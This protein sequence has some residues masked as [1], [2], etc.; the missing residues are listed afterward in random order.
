MLEQIYYGNTVSDYLITISIII[1]MFL[2]AYLSHKVV[3]KFLKKLSKKSKNEYDDVIAEFLKGISWKFY[4]Y[5]SVYI[6]SFSLVLSKMVSRILEIG[7]IIFIA[8]YI[9]KGLFQVINFYVDKEYKKREREKTSGASMIWVLG[10]IGKFFIILAILFT[11]LSNLG[12]KITPLI[13]GFGIGGVALALA[14]QAILGDLFSAF[15]IYFDKPFKEGDFIIIGNDMGIVNYIGIKS[16]RIKTLQ[17]QELVVSNNELTSTRINNYG[18]MEKRRI[19]SSFGVTYDTSTTK[20]KKINR[21]VK[22]ILKDTKNAELD[23]VHFKE[24][25]DFS[26]NYEFVYYVNTGDYYKYMNIR[27]KINLE[28]KKE[29]EKEGIEFAFPTQTIIT[30]KE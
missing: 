26:L 3:I 18:K 19:V 25:G 7:L 4:F 23:R 12:I 22:G 20:L 10:I 13:T 11:L 24:F 17:G 29:F 27:E 14:S 15:T 16:T 8:Y 28:L 6:S 2:I 21:I 9:M 1:G 30:K 5:F